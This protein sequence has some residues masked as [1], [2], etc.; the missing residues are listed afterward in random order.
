MEEELRKL[1]PQRPQRQTEL[2]PR[3]RR[4]LV[5]EDPRVSVIPEADHSD[6]EEEEDSDGPILYRDDDEE[7]D[8]DDEPL[9]TSPHC[10]LSSTSGSLSGKLYKSVFKRVCRRAGQPCEEEGHVRPEAGETG[11]GGCGQL[12]WQDL[13]QQGAVGSS[14]E[15]DRSHAHSVRP[16]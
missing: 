2:E 15:Q 5:V 14:E 6:S 4:A 10:F 11:E 9:S 1:K 13:E 12:R 7:D 16:E 3:S 8:D